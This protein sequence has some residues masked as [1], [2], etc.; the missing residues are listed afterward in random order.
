MAPDAPSTGVEA[1]KSLIEQKIDNLRAVNVVLKACVNYPDY[2]WNNEE[3]EIMVESKAIMQ[4][5]VD[6]LEVHIEKYGPQNI[7]NEKDKW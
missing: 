1:S 3:E 2:V 7:L 6:S 5:I 4:D